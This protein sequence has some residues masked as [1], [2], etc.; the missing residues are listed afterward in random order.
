M[1]NQYIFHTTLTFTH[2]FDLNYPCKPPDYSNSIMRTVVSDVF[3]WT[4]YCVVNKL[5]IY[6]LYIFIRG[7]LQWQKYM[8]YIYKI[9]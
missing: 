4:R 7:V 6:N 2:L 8:K 5:L 1:N 9:I 3:L